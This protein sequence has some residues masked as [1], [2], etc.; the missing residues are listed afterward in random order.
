MKIIWESDQK[1]FFEEHLASYS[2]S[3]EEGS[4]KKEFWPKVIAEWFKEW[5]LSVPPAKLVEEKGSVELAEKVW[6]DKR[7]EVSVL[8][9]YVV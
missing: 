7:I 2:C 8:Q 4:L 9:R 5:P 6:R 1:R 3:R